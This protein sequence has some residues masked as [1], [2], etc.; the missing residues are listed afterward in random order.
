MSHPR[1][2]ASPFCCPSSGSLNLQHPDHFLQFHLLWLTLRH[3]KT[4]KS[5]FAPQGLH[6]L[7]STPVHL[8]PCTTYAPLRVTRRTTHHI[9]TPTRHVP[10]TNQYCSPQHG[11]SSRHTNFPA[12]MVGASGAQL[13]STRASEANSKRPSHPPPS[14]T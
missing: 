5:P 13:L 4:R 14:G 6:S 12:I 11:S 8:Y 1:F 3:P 9:S 2:T 7:T 10:R